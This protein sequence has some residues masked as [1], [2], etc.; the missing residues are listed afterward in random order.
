M[1]SNGHL[2]LRLR[3]GRWIP[4]LVALHILSPDYS[5]IV[6]QFEKLHRIQ[7]SRLVCLKVLVKE[8][9]TNES[10]HLSIL[11]NGLICLFSVILD[12]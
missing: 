7:V 3:D 2:H 11:F 4:A 9:Q 6:L 5:H 1:S 12:L 10:C 8:F